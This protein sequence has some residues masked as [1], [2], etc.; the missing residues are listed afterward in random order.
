MP[1]VSAFKLGI[2]PDPLMS[3]SE[4]SD[5]KRMLPSKSSAE[6]GR[7]R[8]SRTPYL[9]EIMEELSPQ[10]PTQEVKVIKATQLGFCLALDTKIAT[11]DGFSTMRELKIDDVVFDERG[12]RCKVT[13]KSP[14]YTTH[15]CFKITFDDGNCIVADANH[16]WLVNK[17]SNTQFSARYAKKIVTTTQE[18]FSDF[19]YKGKKRYSID[20]AN[21]IN[22]PKIDLP[23]HPY[24]LGIWLGDGKQKGNEIGL[25]SVDA[26]Y[27]LKKF[28]AMGIPYRVKKR[29]EQHIW[30]VKFGTGHG[31]VCLRGHSRVNNTYSDGS[32][33]TC[34]SQRKSGKLDPILQNS[35]LFE[36][37]QDLGVTKCKHIPKK[38]L[39][40]SA[41]QRIALLQGLM[42]TDGY[43]DA[44]K[45]RCGFDSSNRVLIEDV[46]TLIASLGFKVS[47]KSSVR[48][49]NFAS[50]KI[51]YRL[52]F[53][54]YKGDMVA[55]LKRKL[56]NLKERNNRSHMSK[57]RRIINIEEVATVPVQCIEVDSPSHLFLATEHFIPTH[58]TEL[59]NNAILCYMDLY[60]CPIQMIMPTEKLASKHSKAKLTPSIK[61]IPSIMKKVKD[62]KTKDDAGG[63]FEKEFDGGMFSLGWSNS[64]ASFASFSARLVILDDVERFP[65]DVEGEGSP[66]DLGRNRADAFPN[67]KIYI[68][69][70]PKNKNG[71]IDREYQDSDQREY[72]M[73]CPHCGKLITFDFNEDDQH[74]VFEYESETFELLS[75][76]VEYRCP[77]CDNLISEYEKTAMMSKESGAKWVPNNPGHY[78]KGY[79]LNSFYSPLGWVSWL[80]IIREYLKSKKAEAN[81]NTSL[82]RKF[83]N[84]RLAMPYEEK[85]ESTSSDDF[86]MLKNEIAP[87]VVPNDTAA[88]VM[89]IDVQIDHF[90]YKVVA[91]QYGAGKHTVRYGRAESW[92]ELEEIMRTHYSGQKSGAYA[93]TMAAVDSGFKKDEVYE[94][95]AMNSDVAIPV[96]GASTKPDTPWKVSNVERDIN[97]ETIKTGLKL[98]VIDT[99]YFKDMLHAQIERSILLKKE[100][101]VGEN[102]FSMHSESDAFYAK[103]MTSEHKH[104]E[105]NKKT[106]AEKWMWIKNVSKGDNHYWDDAVYTTFL[107]ELLGIRFLQRESIAPKKKKNRH[108]R[109]SSSVQDD[110]MS[111]F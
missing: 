102:T 101:K 45:G 25:Y 43:I 4:W 63:S 61:S 78:H 106:G 14:V 62:A 56:A 79:K 73:P 23:A 55:T 16:K 41:E 98:Y 90:W 86:L 8:T 92:A 87:G 2:K 27:I 82:I 9:Q 15:R 107:G 26:P 39:F 33:K 50:N 110:Y 59:A 81:G 44:K 18:M 32:C 36:V 37:L 13:Y 109:E 95:C 21:A 52:H 10:S 28:D 100:E 22:L 96:K 58:N 60:P 3:I 35:K 105:I 12:D 80:A 51:I 75:D 54:A 20:N 29:D 46:K 77:E 93:V 68:N 31:D 70:T 83:F 88:L 64:A 57:R 74:F 11:T 24:F 47:L 99:E 89:A 104:C 30:V 7:W 71:V 49:T 40:A 65:E 67:R 38:Y 42:D 17:F 76:D 97:G 94:F 6:P 85:F 53:Q 111:N 19:E 91:L 34:K 69:S 108:R 5:T 48:D 72:N 103:Q 84:T 1:Y 66:V